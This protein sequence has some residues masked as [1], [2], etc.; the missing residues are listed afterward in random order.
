MDAVMRINDDEKEN[1][2]LEGLVVGVK[3]INSWMEKLEEVKTF[4]DENGRRPTK[5]TNE[6][7]SNWI[8]AQISNI[9]TNTRCISNKI[10]YEKWIEF[11]NDIKYKKYFDVDFTEIWKRNLQ[12]L[13]EFID[14]N[15]ARPT[16]ITNAKLASWLGHQVNIS[17]K[18][19][20]IMKNDIIYNIW[21]NFINDDKYKKYFDIENI[22]IEKWINILNKLKNFININNARPTINSNAKLNSWITRNINIYKNKL[23]IMKYEIIYNLWNKFISDATYKKYFDLDNIRDWKIKLEEVKKFILENKARPTENTNKSL[24]RW[25][26]TQITNSKRRLKIMKNDEIYN[27][28][29]ECLNVGKFN[30]FIN[31]DNIA[32]WK[33]HFNEFKLYIDTNNKLPLEKVNKELYIWYQRQISIFKKK[34]SIMKNVEIYKIWSEFI[35]NRNYCKFFLDNEI[36]WKKM[37]EKL[38]KYLDTNN[39]R[40]T[41]KNNQELNNWVK[42]QITTFNKKINIMKNETIYN[43]WKSFINEDKY[44][45][46]FMNNDEIWKIN[47]NKLKL[48]ID[49][50]QAKPTELT[51]KELFN[52]LRTQ[53]ANYKNMNKIFKNKEILRHWVEFIND[54]KYKKYFQ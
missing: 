15:K 54:N 43:L 48:F 51:N 41:K 42:V 13:K 20:A 39:S 6:K 8:Q 17:K 14:I 9:E 12:L 40:P 5:K 26:Q 38:K 53:R 45:V 22:K 47:L 30:K 16:E 36:H 52:W 49:K 25:I 44:N 21:Q 19:I 34:C 3:G 2:R 23:G 31:I 46:Y 37:F 35:N 11:T 18:R 27:I 7:L 33:Q 28:W 29:C 1:A 4:I 32:I 24:D 50:N 10:V